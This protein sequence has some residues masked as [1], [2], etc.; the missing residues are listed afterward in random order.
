MGQCEPSLGNC[1]G[2]VPLWH[3]CKTGYTHAPNRAK[4]ENFPSLVIK[5]S[6]NPTVGWLQK[7]TLSDYPEVWDC[8][9]CSRSGALTYE[10]DTFHGQG[11]NSKH[12]YFKSISP[13]KWT[14]MPLIRSCHWKSHFKKIVRNSSFFFFQMKTKRSISYKFTIK[15]QLKSI[16]FKVSW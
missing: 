10:L 3:L 8:W 5:I 1:L 13:L 14:D 11:C 6:K 16:F 2:C 7:I 4:Y 9:T 15:D 12:S